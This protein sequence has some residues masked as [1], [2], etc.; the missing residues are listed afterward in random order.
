MDAKNLKEVVV[1]MEQSTNEEEDD[2]RQDP[3]L[4]KMSWISSTEHMLMVREA[5]MV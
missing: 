2:R 1:M 3:V 5:W 4:Q